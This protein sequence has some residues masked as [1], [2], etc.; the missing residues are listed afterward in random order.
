MSKRGVVN[1]FQ[2]A[3]LLMLLVAAAMLAAVTTMHFAIH[4]AEVAVPSLKGMT[5]A[6]ARSETSGLGLNLDVD[7][8]YYSAAVAAGH[9]L[10]QSPAPG[11]VVRREWRVRV[12][13]SLG[14]QKVEVPDTTGH[15]QRIAALE[16][17]RAGL[18]V[19]EVAQLPYAKAAEGTVLA[20]DPPA[21][22]HGIERPSIGLLLAVADTTALDGFVMPN[23]VG[24]QLGSAQ[25]QLAKVGIQSLPPTMVDAPVAPIGSGNQPIAAPVR[26]GAVVVEEPPAGS[27]VFQTTMVKLTVAR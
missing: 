19:G 3:S 13:E 9:I 2:I 6:E 7:N 22:A 18:E 17:R 4:G 1:F 25:A 16:L 11:T 14:P 8:R 27:R 10:T 23:L 12:A 26:P 24:L 15:E 5:V 20:Q 21:H